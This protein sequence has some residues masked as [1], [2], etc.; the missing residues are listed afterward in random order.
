MAAHLSFTSASSLKRKRDPASLSSDLKPGPD[1]RV[2]T[3]RLISPLRYG[4]PPRLLKLT[5]LHQLPQKSNS[6]TEESLLQEQIAPHDSQSRLRPPQI[7]RS[8]SAHSPF[9]SHSLHS[10]GFNFES[11]AKPQEFHVDLEGQT[12][13]P[14]SH[15]N[16]SVL[17]YRIFKSPPRVLASDRTNPNLGA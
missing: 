16:T 9:L 8:E 6:L 5:R 12:R 15:S 17:N 13:S 14:F 7:H 2:L 1:K 4:P 10:T 11:P 3:D